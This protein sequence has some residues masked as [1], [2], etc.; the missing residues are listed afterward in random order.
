MQFCLMSPYLKTL[1]GAL[2]GK[3]ENN[4]QS[5]LLS[6]LSAGS[7]AFLWAGISLHACEKRYTNA[8]WWVFKVIWQPLPVLTRWGLQDI[9][10]T[11]SRT[12]I[13]EES[14]SIKGFVD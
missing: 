1:R 5:V 12:S 10:K 8:A 13:L 7:A 4:Q 14:C 9:G 6:W 2:R 3:L 11:W